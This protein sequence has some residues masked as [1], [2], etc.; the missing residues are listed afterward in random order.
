MWRVT[1]EDKLTLT[2]DLYMV[3]QEHERKQNKLSTDFVEK[4]PTQ[5]RVPHY[6]SQL[7]PLGAASLTLSCNRV[8]EQHFVPGD[9]NGH[10]ALT[11][12][13]SLT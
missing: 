8:A 9:I 1:G 13:N 2:S 7:P 6:V 3:P 4:P 11:V 5:S 12:S 10:K